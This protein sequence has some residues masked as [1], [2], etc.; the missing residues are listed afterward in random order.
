MRTWALIAASAATVFMLILAYFFIEP[1]PP[2]RIKIAAGPR[3]GGYYRIATQIAE[4]VRPYGVRVDVLETHG[5]S[6]NLALLG[7]HSGPQFALFQSGVTPPAGID[8]KAVTTLATIDLEPVW[9]F[10]RR[11]VDVRSLRDL[12]DKR[13][14][15]G[16]R[17]SGTYDLFRL[18]TATA[19]INSRG[20]R[21]N[22]SNQDAADAFS[23]GRADV[24][25]SVMRPDAPWFAGLAKS[26]DFVLVELAEQEA[27][28]RQQRFLSLFKLPRGALDLR[29]NIPDRDIRMLATSTTL[30]TTSK[31]HA[32]TKM[33]VL[34]ALK[35]IDHGTLLFGTL[36][37]FPSLTQL[38]YPADAEARRFFSSGLPLIRRHLPYW[39]ANMVER[40]YAFVL[41]L[42]TFLI[43]LG[44]FL[45]TW[46]ERRRARTIA[47]WYEKLAALERAVADAPSEDDRLAEL[48]H[49]LHRLER[50]LEDHREDISPPKEYFALRFHSERIHRELWR[51]LVAGWMA[52]GE[53]SS[54][55]G[56]LAAL[57]DSGSLPRDVLLA[58]VERELELIGRVE[59]R[60]AGSELPGELLGE[61][62]DLRRAL[63]KARDR[64]AQLA[65]SPTVTD[66][67]AIGK[68]ERIEPSPR[69]DGTD[70]ARSHVRLVPDHHR[71]ASL[72]QSIK[73]EKP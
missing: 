20:T 11:G 73:S 71:G 50:A 16:D 70:S 59:Q 29:R 19:G 65:T 61:V 30:L 55:R 17:G 39:L 37:K 56:A 41:P 40:W 52:E 68:I 23:A 48:S 35:E 49:R 2:Q 5:A 26:T 10:A 38:E 27:F 4:K 3:D 57:P 18:L 6:D 46:I 34:Q 63:E 25:F 45:P 60:H 1:A 67:P 54:A 42:L 69:R 51:K 66:V 62:L 13:V 15:V 47:N 28:V 24:L 21:I 58:S 12:A 14:I 44:H 32:A 7:G 64:L 8:L 43:P 33:L 9:I 36:D 72:A 31:V 22:L 53:I